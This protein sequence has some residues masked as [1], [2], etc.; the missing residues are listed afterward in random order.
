MMRLN[1]GP[2]SSKIEP[3]V[4]EER[5]VEKSNHEIPEASSQVWV[6]ICAS[7]SEGSTRTEQRDV[8]VLFAHQIDQHT[9]IEI[10]AARS[11]DHPTG[12]GQAH[13]GVNGLTALNGGETGAIAEMQNY[14]SIRQ[15]V[16]KL[17]YDRLA[18]KAVK[19]IAV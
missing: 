2:R 8:E 13:A 4:F 9:R 16:P 19:S 5:Q 12:R 7:S 15:I 3:P 18:R 17:A 6:A 1:A 14:Q 11:H 10:A